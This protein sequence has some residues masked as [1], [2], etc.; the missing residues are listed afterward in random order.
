MHVHHGAWRV[1]RGR[2]SVETVQ[3]V[4][5]GVVEAGEGEH[6]GTCGEARQHGSD[7][8]EGEEA[9]GEGFSAAGPDPVGPQRG[10]GEEGRDD[11]DDEAPFFVRLEAVEEDEGEVGDHEVG[12]SVAECGL[13]EGEGD[14]EEVG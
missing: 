6:E 5:A 14:A 2:E 13:G 11:V 8:R 9:V 10:G 1:V 7:E 3:S 12:G 4:R